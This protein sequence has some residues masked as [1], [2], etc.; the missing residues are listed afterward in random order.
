MYTILMYT[1][2]LLHERYEV[3]FIKLVRFNIK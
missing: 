1:I 2:S 3:D